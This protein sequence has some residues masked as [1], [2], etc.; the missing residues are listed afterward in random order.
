MRRIE[1]IVEKSVK[2]AKFVGTVFDQKLA[3]ELFER[4][5]ERKIDWQDLI[6]NQM[7][8]KIVKRKTETGNSVTTAFQQKF[9]FQLFGFISKLIFR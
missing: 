8:Q 7:V 4:H 9:T 6:M 5:F 2:C 1:K 3:F